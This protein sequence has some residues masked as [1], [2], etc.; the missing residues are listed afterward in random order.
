MLVHN[1]SNICSTEKPSSSEKYLPPIDMEKESQQVSIQST[2]NL[3]R[4]YHRPADTSV[5]SLYTNLQCIS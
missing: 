3:P 2:K 1:N 4:H 5:S